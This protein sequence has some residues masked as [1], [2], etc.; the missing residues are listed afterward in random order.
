MRGE[1]ERHSRHGMAAASLR[2][3]SVDNHCTRAVQEQLHAKGCL[4]TTHAVTGP[5]HIATPV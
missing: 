2:M 1:E 4:D 5:T 3:G